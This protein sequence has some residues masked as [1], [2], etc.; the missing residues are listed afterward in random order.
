MKVLGREKK[1]YE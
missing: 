1:N